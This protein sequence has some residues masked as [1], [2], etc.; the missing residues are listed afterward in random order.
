MLTLLVTAWLVPLFMIFLSDLGILHR[1][2]T[3]NINLTVGRS[4]SLASDN[5][6]K[7]DVRSMENGLNAIELKRNMTHQAKRVT[8][9]INESFYHYGLA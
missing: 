1:I 5:S 3:T 7:N 4:R 6:S 8:L 9:S 2:R